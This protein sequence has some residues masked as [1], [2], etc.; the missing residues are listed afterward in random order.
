MQRFRKSVVLFDMN[1]S[2]DMT[3]A[4]D[5]LVKRCLQGDSQA[6]SALYN[7]YHPL[8][9]GV[10]LHYVPDGEAARDIE[11]DAWV[12]ILTSLGTLNDSAHFKP[13]ATA[14]VRN[15]SLNYL[16]HEQVLRQVPLMTD[17]PDTPSRD[18]EDISLPVIMQMVA[19]L[20]QGYERVFRLRTFEGMSHQQIAHALGISVSTSRSQLYHARQMLQDMLRRYWALLLLALMAPIAYLVFNKNSE[21]LLVPHESPTAHHTE[22]AHNDTIMNQPL[23]S[24]QTQPRAVL[25]PARI[26]AT[27]GIAVVSTDTVTVAD[28]VMP[29]VSPLSAMPRLALA[30][31]SWSID[32]IH[33]PNRLPVFM[34]AMPDVKRQSRRLRLHLAYGGAPA[35]TTTTID[36]FL[37]VINFAAGGTQRT[38]RIY[39]WKDYADYLRA[40][41]QLMDSSQSRFMHQVIGEHADTVD[42]VDQPVHSGEGDTE[43]IYD[44][45]PLSEVKHHER[46]RTYMLSLAYPLNPR[47]NLVSGLGLTTMRSTF[48]SGDN[49]NE[50]AVR[51]QRLYYLTLPVGATYNI[52]Q[53]KRLSLYATGSVQLDLPVRGRETTRYLY[54]GTAGHAPG[55]SLV[56]PTT[57][58]TIRAPWQWSV[59][60]GLGVQMRLLP[61]VDAYF[62]P[63]FRY[64]IPTHSP[65][66]NYR[67]DHPWDIA[68]PFGIRF[69]P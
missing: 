62:E 29:I 41:E 59:G 57:H 3:M 11:H 36:N 32:T 19:Q 54:T 20:P 53:Y 69:T 12:M 60:A 55:D 42:K 9:M 37:S 28:S 35:G 68:L 1:A 48:E 44:T 4:T 8:L 15:M 26:G 22:P 5:D 21:Q 2:G 46:P 58:A 24:T 49:G 63:N 23:T 38:M 25:V 51:T 27:E 65:V 61:H 17:V 64:Y 43:V 34:S 50:K 6:L 18:A 40:N 13:W 31:P 66:E 30:V 56:F 47:W 52:W 33:I 45:T 14:I 7:Q 10:A 67:T 39:S 16:K